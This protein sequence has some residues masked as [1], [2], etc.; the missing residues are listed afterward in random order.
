MTKTGSIFLF[1]AATIFAA[2]PQFAQGPAA[3]KPSFDVISIKPTAPGQRGGGSGMRGDK[4]TMSGITVRSLLLTAYQPLPVGPAGGVVAQ[5]QVVGGPPWIESERYDVQATA[6]CSGGAISRQQVQ[7]M[8]RSMLED[9]FQLKAHIETRDLPVYN[10]VVGRDGAK[11]KRSEDQTPVTPTQVQ[12][13]QLCAPLPP[14]PTN[15]PPPL[16]P[17]GQRGSPFDPNSPVPR[18]FMGAS[19][20]QSMFMLRGSAVPLSNMIGMMQQQVGRPVID[21]TELKGL[22]DFV[23]RFSPEGLNSSFSQLQAQP[24]PPLPGGAP[25]GPGAAPAGEPLPSIFTALQEIGLRL[26]STK[27]PLEVLVIDSV[28]RPTEN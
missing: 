20:S 9:R 28:Q 8:V 18:G 23:I 6:D 27:A 2:F 24:P 7:P 10:L 17:P 25:A 12:P 14:A 15:T 26:E 5:L 19:F 1:A 22:Y 4:Y 13:P 21:K 11:V 16:I 3:S